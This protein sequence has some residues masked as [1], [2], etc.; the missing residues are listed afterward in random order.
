MANAGDN[1]FTVLQ[2]RA[3]ELTDAARA[4]LSQAPVITTED[5]AGKLNDFLEQISKH[6][7]EVDDARKELKKP[8]SDAA[9]AVDDT[10]KPVMNKLDAVRALIKPLRLLWLQKKEA[11][12]Q[13]E[14]K[15]AEAEAAAAEEA[16]QDAVA[17]AEVAEGG[18]IMDAHMA[19]QAAED[20]AT[21]ARDRA[22]DLARGKT[23][24]KGEY[25]SKA[26]GLRST[27]YA[28]IDDPQ[29]AFLTFHD[30][31]DVVAVLEKLAS[32]EA[33]G[34]RRRLSGFSILEKQSAA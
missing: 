19:S 27:W 22:D 9:K 2:T 26:A 21:E 11:E 20:A 32:A 31:P 29:K 30:H 7:K 24:L 14:V 33:R 13:E 34:G 12:R 15:K 6:I 5:Q 23:S 10:F 18:N 1:I 4:W 8:H 16:A 25:G 17:E 28:V 3:T